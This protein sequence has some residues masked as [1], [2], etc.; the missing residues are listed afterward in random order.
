MIRS[1]GRPYL[2]AVPLHDALHGREPDTRAGEI[3][4]AMQPLEEVFHL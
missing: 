3:I 1:A 4:G 2:A